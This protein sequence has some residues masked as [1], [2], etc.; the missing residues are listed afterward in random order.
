MG[1]LNPRSKLSKTF[2]FPTLLLYYSYSTAS[3]T[4]LLLA[5]GGCAL[6][7]HSV[8]VPAFDTFRRTFPGT[9]LGSFSLRHLH[10]PRGAGTG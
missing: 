3:T 2:F 5:P 9:A 10:T 4:L 8:R 1:T 6:C 7:T